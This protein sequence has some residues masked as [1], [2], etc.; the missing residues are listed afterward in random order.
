MSSASKRFTDLLLQEVLCSKLGIERHP[1]Y[2]Y[3]LPDILYP[4]DTVE[5]EY[6]NNLLDYLQYMDYTRIYKED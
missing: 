3:K 6:M 5:E 1:F 2:S 4:T